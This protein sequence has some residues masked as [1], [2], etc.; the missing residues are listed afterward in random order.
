MCKKVKGNKMAE[1]IEV[2][3][4][5]VDE[6]ITKALLLLGITSDKLEYEVKEKGSNGILGIGAKPTV[7]LA[8]KMMNDIDYGIEFLEKVMSHMDV[9]AEVS[10][11]ENVEEN[12]LDIE[13]A[14]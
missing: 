3:A 12:Y 4:K 11:K 1:Y 7:I 6:A 8:R 9:K 2:S 10:V 13:L 14:G 5:N